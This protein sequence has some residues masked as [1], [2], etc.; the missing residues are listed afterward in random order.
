MVDTGTLYEDPTLGTQV[1]NFRAYI[2]GGVL[3]STG[4]VVEFSLTGTASG[5]DVN[6]IDFVP[7]TTVTIPAF[8]TG[9]DFTLTGLN[10]KLVEDTEDIIVD[11]SGVVNA[12]EFGTQT[13]TLTIIDNDHA[14]LLISANTGALNENDGAALVTITIS[15]DVINQGPVQAQLYFTGTAIMSLDY[16]TFV[17]VTIPAFTTGRTFAVTGFNDFFVEGDEP[18]AITIT[19]VNN[20]VP[21]IYFDTTVFGTQ[22]QN[23]TIIDDDVIYVDLAFDTGTM[24]ESSGMIVGSLLVSGGVLTSVSGI[25]ISLTYAGLAAN[26]VDYHTGTALAT[27]PAGS[28]GTTFVLTGMNDLIVEGDETFTIDIETVTGGFEDGA[29]SGTLTIID[30]DIIYVLLTG[31]TGAINEFVGSGLDEVNFTLYTSGDVTSITGIIVYLDYTGSAL[32]GRDID[33]GANPV[34]IP[35]GQTGISFT[36]TARDDSFFE[37][38][39]E[40]FDVLIT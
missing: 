10:D 17:N 2:S 31:N 7:V 13:H 8:S 15:G 23:L 26:G 28:T 5:N 16:T 34:I 37:G 36:I 30:D 27:I 38:G 12:F 39:N 14:Q 3:V 25:D 24:A 18:F 19:G 20:P 9:V 21:L 11:I 29:Q 32:N 4:V 22:T 1:A 6:V 33:T 40:T 35:A